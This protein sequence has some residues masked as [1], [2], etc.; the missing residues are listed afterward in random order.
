[1]LS[2]ADLPRTN[3]IGG[4]ELAATSRSG[5]WGKQEM[6][7]ALRYALCI[8]KV[9]RHLD[10][11]DGKVYK[12][13]GAMPL[14]PELPHRQTDKV[15]SERNR[16]AQPAFGR[17]KFIPMPRLNPSSTMT[18]RPLTNPDRRAGA[19]NAA[20]VIPDYAGRTL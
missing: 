11:P 20:R 19:D 17:W 4:K 3:E 10:L 5:R 14:V 2:G 16:N 13:V 7:I 9:V 1:V 15:Q 12:N 6:R 8:R 18:K